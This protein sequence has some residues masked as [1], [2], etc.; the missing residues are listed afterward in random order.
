MTVEA[1]FYI[2]SLPFPESECSQLRGM[3]QRKGRGNTT[4]GTSWSGSEETLRA[5]V[6]N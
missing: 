6:R 1:S 5:A 2:S 3:G 4:N